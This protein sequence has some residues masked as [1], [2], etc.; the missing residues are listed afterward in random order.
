MDTTGG[1][2]FA[3]VYPKLE[4]LCR[5]ITETR[6]DTFPEY[7]SEQNKTKY[8]PQVLNVQQQPGDSDTPSTRMPSNKH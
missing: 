8:S 6:H 5:S 1:A 3:H 2:V 4:R 7:T